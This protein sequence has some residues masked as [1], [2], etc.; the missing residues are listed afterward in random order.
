MSFRLVLTAATF[1]ELKNKIVE[2][3]NGL[4]PISVIKEEKEE[5]IELNIAPGPAPGPSPDEEAEM[6]TMPIEDTPTGPITLPSPPPAIALDPHTLD[7]S[8]L[9]W[10]E[11]IHASSKAMTAKGL[12]RTKRNLPDGLQEE[13]ELELRNKNKAAPLPIPPPPVGIPVAVA[14]PVYAPPAPAPVAPPVFAVPAVPV[15]PVN[16]PSYADNIVPASAPQKP[17]HTLESFRNGMVMTLAQLVNA[18]AID[19]NYIQSLKQY[20]GV[21]EVWHIASDEAKS[22]ELFEQLVSFGMITKVG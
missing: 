17:A 6:E 14:P 8:G 18:G 1:E 20:F 2:T 19:Q 10:D 3:Y 15:E 12:W 21:K 4:A 11:R 7:S 22:R 5:E 13:V 16:P 9:P